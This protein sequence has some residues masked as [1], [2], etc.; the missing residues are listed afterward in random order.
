MCILCTAAQQG[1]PSDVLPQI[2]PLPV[3][4]AATAQVACARLLLLLLK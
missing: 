1:V 2:G 3:I 4:P